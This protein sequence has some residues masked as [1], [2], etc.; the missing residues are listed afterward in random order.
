MRVVRSAAPVKAAIIA[1]TSAAFSTAILQPRVVYDPRQGARE[2]RDGRARSVVKIN[3]GSGPIRLDGWINV[4]LDPSLRPDVVTEL[5][6]GVPFASGAVDFIFAE[7]LVAYLGL[8]GLRVFL[9]EC[10]RILKP[11]GAM[12]VL[13][14]DLARLARMYLEA[15]A[16]LVDLWN[17]TVGVPVTTGTACE[18]M[19]LAMEL[20]GRFPYDSATLVQLAA[21]AGFDAVRVGY[22]ESR[23]APLACLDCRKPRESLSMYH[24][25]YPRA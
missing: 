17:R 22:R 23:F 2:A 6:R 5:T 9:S 1:E 7:D 8:P 13:T 11:Q 12:R 10:R 24:E 15:P 21:E 25:F 19:N 20:A 4:D 16:E 14:P 3:F 18:V